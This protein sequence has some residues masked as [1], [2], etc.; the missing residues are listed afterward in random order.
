MILDT[1]GAVKAMVGGR[2]YRESPF[3]RAVDAKR[4]PGSTFKPFVFL[5]G[6][7]KGLTPESLV[8]DGPVEVDGW[9]PKNYNSRYYGDVTLRKGWP[10]R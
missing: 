7:E 2:D 3:N 5:A 10:G 6:L 4:Q 9:E 8:H 1:D